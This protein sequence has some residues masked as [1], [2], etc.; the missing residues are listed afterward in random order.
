MLLESAVLLYQHMH[1]VITVS[2]VTASDTGLHSD[3][4]DAVV[5]QFRRVS[6]DALFKWIP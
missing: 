2:L 5:Y 3:T 6:C 1:Y 4:N